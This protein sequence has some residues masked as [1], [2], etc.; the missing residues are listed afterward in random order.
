MCEIS[1]GLLCEISQASTRTLRSSGLSSS[2]PFGIQ[3]R[4]NIPL[5]SEE[6]GCETVKRV[7]TIS[8]S[9]RTRPLR[10]RVFA[11]KAL[12]RFPTRGDLWETRP[13]GDTPRVWQRTHI[14]PV[15][16]PQWRED[17]LFW[18]NRRASLLTIWKRVPRF[19]RTR[20][21]TRRLV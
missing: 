2:V 5:N 4:N 14:A 19:S 18:K 3:Q 21:A 12:D 13:S 16:G 8:L 10:E 17:S 1:Q 6:R 20:F 7:E 9:L 11:Q 15:V